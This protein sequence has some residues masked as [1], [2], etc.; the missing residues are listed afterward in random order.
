MEKEKELF[1]RY[2]PSNQY[3]EYISNIR[4]CYAEIF[5]ESTPKPKESQIKK[6]QVKKEEKNK[7]NEMEPEVK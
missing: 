4:R 1:E 2:I 5:P 3:Q 7:N 6:S